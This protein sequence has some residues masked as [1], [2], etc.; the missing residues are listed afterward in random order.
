MF[1]YELLPKYAILDA[2]L[3]TTSPAS[4]AAA[5]GIDA[6]IHVQE[7]YVSNAASPFSDAMAE[8]AMELIG[9]NIRR[10]VARRTDSEAAEAMMVGSLFAGIAFSFARLGNV[11]AMS[12]PVSAFFDVQHGV[13]NAVLLPVVVEYNA[14][15]DHGKYYKIYNYISKIKVSEEVFEPMMLVDAIK[16]L[17][18]DIGIPENLTV[19]INQ[20]SKNGSISREAIAE[21]N[22]T[23]GY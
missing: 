21:K 15:A 10:F 17:C 14:L 5:C 8:K 1:S 7:A 12:H 4:V 2:E 20:A 13:A 23:H 9:A 16:S 22:R 3:I 18:S 6:F 19:A 11:H